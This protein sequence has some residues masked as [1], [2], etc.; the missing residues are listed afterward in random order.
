MNYVTRSQ[1]LQAS[2]FCVVTVNDG[3][4]EPTII[5]KIFGANSSFHVN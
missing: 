4:T 5:H 3:H 2:A 1:G